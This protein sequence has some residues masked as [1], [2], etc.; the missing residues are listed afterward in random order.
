METKKNPQEITKE[1]WNET[2]QA[3]K[4]CK[5]KQEIAKEHGL[6]C[7]DGTFE[8]GV[9]ELINYSQNLRYKGGL[10]ADM[11]TKLR[12]KQINEQRQLYDK[13]ERNKETNQWLFWIIIF[14][15]VIGCIIL[16]N[17]KGVI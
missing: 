15:I 6:L 10:P 12:E 9:R 11:P 14:I 3:I 13:K 1:K 8:G 7:F 17:Y 4:D 16:S 5:D 2:I